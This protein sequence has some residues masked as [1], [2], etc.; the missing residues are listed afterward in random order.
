[1]KSFLDSSIKLVNLAVLIITSKPIFEI[2]LFFWGG[3]G[4]VGGL[5]NYLLETNT[6]FRKKGYDYES[7]PASF[8]R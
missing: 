3:G 8:C 1:M 6:V 7:G 4:Q 2:S 5:P